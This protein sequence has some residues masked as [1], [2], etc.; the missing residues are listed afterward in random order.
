[1]QLCSVSSGDEGVFLGPN[2]EFGRV[3]SHSG[4]REGKKVKRTS[5]TGQPVAGSALC[6]LSRTSPPY[7]ESIILKLDHPRIST[8]NILV[9][10]KGEVKI[11]P[12]I[13]PDEREH[14]SADL[15]SLGTIM[16]QM[17]DE[18]RETLKSTAV[19][20]SAEAANFVEV[21][22]FATLDGFSDE[23]FPNL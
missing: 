7:E 12:T 10:L 4:C 8:E 15:N 9:S 3:L 16:L 2:G 1:M 17:I 13:F 20:W 19:D 5:R 6:R 14:A 21:T 22:S 11:D 18:T 23:S